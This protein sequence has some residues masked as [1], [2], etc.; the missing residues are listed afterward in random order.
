MIKNVYPD[1]Y[2]HSICDIGL[3][4]RSLFL[5]LDIDWDKNVT[6]FRI[7]NSSSTHKDNNTF[8]VLNEGLTLGSDDTAIV[9]EDK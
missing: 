2:D 6:V 5:I 3:D 1:K 8:L 7:G 9:A 4:S